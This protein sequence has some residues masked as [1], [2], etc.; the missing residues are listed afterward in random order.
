MTTRRRPTVLTAIAAAAALIGGLTASGATVAAAGTAATKPLPKLFVLAG[1]ADYLAYAEYHSG[2]A[3]AY[4]DGTLHVLQA[5]GVV[6]SLGAIIN[7]AAPGSASGEHYSLVGNMLTAYSAADPTE[8]QWWN[9]ATKLPGA[10]APLPTGATWAGSS[11]DGWAIVEPDGLSTEDVSTSGVQTP[12]GEPIPVEADGGGSISA[13][14]GPDG[15]V[16]VGRVSGQVAYQPWSAPTSV[17]PLNGGQPPGTLSLACD[18]VSTAIVTCV[19][20]TPAGDETAKLAVPLD[21]SAEVLTYDA[22]VGSDVADGRTLVYVCGT[23]PARS[24]FAK[25][26]DDLRSEVPVTT[27]VGVSAFGSYVTTRPGRHTIISLHSASS[28]AV[29]LVDVTPKPPA[30]AAQIDAT[31]LRAAAD[32]V[33]AE[34]L[35]GGA[36]TTSAP[37]QEPAKVLFV[38]AVA[39]IARARAHDPSLAPHDTTG[40]MGPVPTH[41]KHRSAGAPRHFHITRTRTLHGFSHSVPDGGSAGF[42]L[43][44]LHGGAHPA[45]PQPADGVYVD[46][47]LPTIPHP[48][49]GTVALR[50]T[51]GRLGQPYVWAA[52]GPTTFDCSGLMQWAYAH[53]GIRLTHFSGD[54]YN[55]GRLIPGRDILPGDLILFDHRVHGREVIHH[56]GMYLGS[57]WMVN[58]P[59][60]GQY[61]S[62]T[63]VPSGVAGI[64]R[65]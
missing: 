27:R 50:T 23:N 16:S 63:Q 35:N 20:T 38:S 37:Y 6:R 59:Y 54:Q 1:S 25:D 46:P 12:Y 30:T 34:A 26:V 57:G 2:G 21:G 9:L 64:V 60:T 10:F 15:L 14:S 18:S 65:P 61:V 33:E 41:L 5:G 40:L 29:S 52:A 44:R 48:T 22:C 24:H 19:D 39:L 11:P 53:A 58:A 4:A 36:L 49:I 62:V 56:V 28:K 8:V 47:K 55:E 32:D 51:L 17:V 7:P 3:S 43:H 31:A 13:V 45:K 42:G